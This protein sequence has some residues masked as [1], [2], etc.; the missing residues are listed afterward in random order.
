M[1]RTQRAASTV[2]GVLLLSLVPAPSW[3]QEL[4]GRVTDRGTGAPI[5][6]A[7]VELR[8]AGG[9]V[10]RRALTSDQGVWL[11]TS[12]GAEVTVQ[13]EALGYTTWQSSLLP[14][15]PTSRRR[16]D[17][18]LVP[19]PVRLDGISVS[20]DRTCAIHSAA[21]DIMLAWEEARRALRVSATALEQRLVATD[22]QNYSRRV[23]TDGLVLQQTVQPFAA[24]FGAPFESLPAE[25]LLRRGYVRDRGQFI[26]YYAPDAV[27]LLDDA[28]TAAHCFSLQRSDGEPARLG[29]NFSPARRSAVAGIAG[30]VWLDP[31]THQ[32]LSIEFRYV[33]A[34]A[35]P[36]SDRASGSVDFRMLPNGVW[37]I[38]RWMIRTP[39]AAGTASQMR[40]SQPRLTE[41]L[42]QG[43][44]VVAARM[45]S[46]RIVL[47]DPGHVAG[48][49]FDS[50]RAVP[51]A[52][53]DVRIAGTSMRAA[54]DAAGRFRI[55]NVPAGSYVL[56]VEHP[57][58]DS[59]PPFP[60]TAHRIEVTPGATSTAALSVPRLD[61][62]SIGACPSAQQGAAPVTALFGIVSDSAGIAL[63][64]AVL[65]FGW[66]AYAETQTRGVVS[67]ARQETTVTADGRGRY[68]LCGVPAD[69]N[70]EVVVVTGT[71]R[72]QQTLRTPSAPLFTGIQ[73]RGPAVAAPEPI[74]L[75]AIEVA[76]T[77]APRAGAYAGFPVAA[78]GSRLTGAALAR[79]ERQSA[80]VPA[81]VGQLGGIRTRTF[82][83]P[84]GTEVLCVESS[85]STGLRGSGCT[86]AILV[87]DGIVTGQASG[88]SLRSFRLNDFESVEFLIGTHAAHFGSNAVTNGAL[89][90]W[91]RGRGPHRSPERNGG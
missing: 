27:V 1:G 20:S 36:F 13:I 78:P 22:G 62:S 23:S 88:E 54:S 89:I 35:V 73:M 45:G 18:G 41:F 19:Q 29:I 75:D 90:L 49:V 57:R 87:I 31:T 6:A 30:T 72:S 86:N 44:E 82:R 7:I 56:T 8:D 4:T 81:V 16:V 77:S 85:R 64:G 51:L 14:V 59:L 52:G 47:A 17:I 83:L 12:P 43:G 69:R 10:V 65:H 48:S 32:L 2:V 63:P 68:W 39:H 24:R 58:L 84:G 46:Q 15:D 79:L 33:N 5:S 91:T 42:E 55:G 53:A 61:Q 21:A 3:A 38:S 34:A 11:L 80:S 60:A 66:T 76:T 40:T 37:I 67:A 74:P 25:E 26:E 71:V 70:I 28:F 50:T 9:N